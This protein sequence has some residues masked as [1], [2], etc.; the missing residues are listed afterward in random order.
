[1]EL[2]EEIC[3]GMVK[4]PPGKHEVR[5]R[6]ITCFALPINCLALSLTSLGSGLL[7]LE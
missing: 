3:N 2:W 5:G 1:M 7:N 6:E 4:P